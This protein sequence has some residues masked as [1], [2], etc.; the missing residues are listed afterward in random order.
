MNIIREIKSLLD[1]KK[2][3]IKS[4][5]NDHLLKNYKNR[6][7]WENGKGRAPKGKMNVMVL[8]R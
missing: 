6:I 4:K 8:G 1:D 5:P 3:I 2:K 7:N